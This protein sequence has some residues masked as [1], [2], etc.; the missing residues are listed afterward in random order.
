M[1]PLNSPFLHAFFVKNLKWTLLTKFEANFASAHS[2]AYTPL[3]ATLLKPLPALL[4]QWSCTTRIIGI[5]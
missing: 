1:P 2:S 5:G 4:S 3:N